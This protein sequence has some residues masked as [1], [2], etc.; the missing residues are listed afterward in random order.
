MVS[1]REILYVLL[2]TLAAGGGFVDESGAGAG[3]MV[4]LPLL[5]LLLISTDRPSGCVD[6]C[7]RVIPCPLPDPCCNPCLG[8]LG[9]TPG[10]VFG[11]VF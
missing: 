9:T 1:T 6:G 5:L 4:I 7:G 11:R 3:Y 8:R 10:G 2:I